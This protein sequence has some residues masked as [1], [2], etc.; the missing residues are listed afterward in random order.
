M[1]ELADMKRIEL[2]ILTKFADICERNG[3]KYCLAGGTL[4]G[5]VR[6]K[7]FIPWDDDVD[8]FMP[9]PDYMRFISLCPAVLN[10]P[11]KL[12]V[13]YN[14]QD[15]YHPFARVCDM[16]TVY[17]ETRAAGCEL[18]VYIDV[19]PLDGLPADIRR[20]NRHFFWLDKLHRMRLHSVRKILTK[21]S[22]LEACAKLPVYW[23]ARLLGPKFWVRRYDKLMRKYDFESSDYVGML[24][25]LIYGSRE[26][27]DKASVAEYM[28]MEF[29]G[30]RFKAPVGYDRYLKNLYGDYMKLPPEHKRVTQHFFEAE[31]REDG[32]AAQSPGPSPHIGL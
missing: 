21:W 32:A 10:E 16:R 22:F 24:G 18:G 2:H 13:H 28:D 9:R 8:V 20:S 30:L 7:G 5:A 6:H 26:R 11:L 19:F 4:L 14:Q 31:W 25:N 29:E 12:Y 1:L 17:R 15:Y 23:F 3:L 27:I